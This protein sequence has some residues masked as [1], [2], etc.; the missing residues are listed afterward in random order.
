MATTF[1]LKGECL[2]WKNNVPTGTIFA[3][4]AYDNDLRFFKI[5]VRGNIWSTFKPD[6]IQGVL[7]TET[8]SLRKRWQFKIWAKWPN[9]DEFTFTF[10]LP[11]QQSAESA[12][13]N[14]EGIITDS[15]GYD[16]GLRLLKSRERVPGS[17]IAALLK[18]DPKTGTQSA[19]EF[20]ER[21]IST[22]QV[23]GVYE[24]DEFVSRLALQ[25]ETVRYDIVSKFEVN[26]SGA[27][28]LTCPK[29][30]AAIPLET[31]ESNG[32][33]RY[34]GTSFMIPKRI[35]DLV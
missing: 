6:Q 21:A 5:I 22:H 28:V 3:D 35:L 11:S 13:V 1:L 10:T 2:V 8:G 14:I 30:G 29:C 23:D 9:G 34:C 20:V 25:R 26:S 32:K 19:K 17:E 27:L 24:N 18:V 33:C 7:I 15:K 12:K 31:K 4:F 16:E